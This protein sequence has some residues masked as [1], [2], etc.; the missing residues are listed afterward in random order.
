[1]MHVSL[2]TSIIAFSVNACVIIPVPVALYR[3]AHSSELS[4]PQEDLVEQC[5]LEEEIKKIYIVW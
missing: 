3:L 2:G 4:S 1:M 5:P